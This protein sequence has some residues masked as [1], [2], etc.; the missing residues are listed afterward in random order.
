MVAA[1]RVVAV[2]LALV[3]PRARGFGTVD[4]GR[5]PEDV[6]RFVLVDGLLLLV[7]AV[8]ADCCCPETW[9]TDGALPS[10]LGGAFSAG[11]VGL[12][13][14]VVFAAG[15]V[16]NIP[17]S[18]LPEA[19]V[20]VVAAALLAALLR[21]AADADVAVA[22]VPDRVRGLTWGSRLGDEGTPPLVEGGASFWAN[23]LRDVVGWR[24]ERARLSPVVEDMLGICVRGEKC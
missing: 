6:G 9:R 12:V 11:A 20:V 14:R 22:V 15:L 2:L 10:C 24:R 23:W 5:P 13:L 16:E 8:A 17:A 1:V 21:A 18:S 4:V 7:L 19:V 3:C